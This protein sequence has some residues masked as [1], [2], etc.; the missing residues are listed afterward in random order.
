VLRV[1]LADGRHLAFREHD[2]IDVN[3]RPRGACPE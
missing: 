3:L 2:G 1:A